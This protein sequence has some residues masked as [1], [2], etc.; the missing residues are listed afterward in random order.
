MNIQKL[1][2]GKMKN[3]Y[4]FSFIIM[5]LLSNGIGGICGISRSR[6]SITRIHYEQ[7]CL[8]LNIVLSSQ[9]RPNLL[10]FLH[11]HNF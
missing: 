6:H 8:G 9:L 1:S 4:F 10:K 7:L 11:F 2:F 5:L 3:I